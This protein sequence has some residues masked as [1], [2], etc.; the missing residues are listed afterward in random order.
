MMFIVFFLMLVG[1]VLSIYTGSLYHELYLKGH[2]DR[3]GR[4][5]SIK[6]MK[7][8]VAKEIPSDDKRIAKKCLKLYYCFLVIFYSLGILMVCFVVSRIIR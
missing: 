2:H 7:L 5:I 4:R 1:V 8:I 3:F 6:S